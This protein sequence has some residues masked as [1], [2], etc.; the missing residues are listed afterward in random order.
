MTWRFTQ[1]HTT[2]RFRRR[3][4]SSRPAALDPRVPETLE[5]SHPQSLRLNPST[6]AVIHHEDARRRL[7]LGMLVLGMGTAGV[8]VT[9]TLRLGMMIESRRWLTDSEGDDRRPGMSS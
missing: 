8:T 1:R 3:T 7:L 2:P 5:P 9:P 4:V 6:L